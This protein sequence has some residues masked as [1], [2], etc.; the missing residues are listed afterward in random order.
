VRVVPTASTWSRSRRAALQR[1]TARDLSAVFTT[2]RMPKARSG[3]PGTCGRS[4]VE[5]PTAR[6]TLA[7]ASPTSAV[8]HLARA[9]ASIDV[10][11]AVP[12]CAR[13]SEIG[14]RHC[15]HSAGARRAEQSARCRR[16]SSSVVTRAVW[17]GLLEEVLPARRLADTAPQFAASDQPARPEACGAAPRG[18]ART[19]V[20]ADVAATAR[21]VVRARRSR[22]P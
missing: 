5:H 13:I 2:R 7:G 9:D 19:A 11:G 12:I 20:G 18:R 1:R 17:E 21:P 14:R 4:C 16:R 3:L 22:L 15:T 8:R 10:T 6:L